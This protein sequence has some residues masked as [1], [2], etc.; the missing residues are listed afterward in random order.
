[1]PYLR[2][3]AQAFS[4]VKKDIQFQTPE[5]LAYDTPLRHSILFRDQHALTYFAPRLIRLWVLTVGQLLE[6]DSLLTLIAPTW[7]PVTDSG[8]PPPPPPPPPSCATPV[9]DQATWF[10]WARSHMA[11]LLS[12]QHT[13]QRRQ[14][15]EV[16][17]A[18]HKLCL[19]AKQKDFIHRALWKR[20]PVRHRQDKW[21]PLE[22]W[23]PLEGELETIKHALLSC[24][25]LP[26]AFDII[27]T[28]FRSHN[29]PVL[30][31]K[32]MLQH[33]PVASLMTPAGLLGWSAVYTNWQA[34]CAK[35]YRP[36]F[37]ITSELYFQ[38][39]HITISLWDACH[40]YLLIPKET[41]HWFQKF[42]DITAQRPP[43]PHPRCKWVGFYSGQRREQW[44]G[45]QQS[46][47]QLRDTGVQPRQGEVRVNGGLSAW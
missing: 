2:W 33:D 9:P 46:L 12:L 30:S 25:Y 31:V 11:G 28:A 34:R 22:V 47:E 4:L 44:R 1:M 42:L 13:L 18:F 41:F 43:P 17:T 29:T 7:V 20:L 8:C 23:C 14:S 6:D 21:K 27:D 45:F 24:H 36:L 15:E 10:D 26:R 3:S 37:R 32:H 35:K 39:W 19:P 38:R 40:H 16:W 5:L